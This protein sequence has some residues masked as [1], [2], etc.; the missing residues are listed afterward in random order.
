M[1]LIRL[2][3]HLV[4]L[5]LNERGNFTFRGQIVVNLDLL[6]FE[7]IEGR[8]FAFSKQLGNEIVG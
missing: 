2:R 1:S 4:T 3:I 5:R 7:K 8:D 6:F